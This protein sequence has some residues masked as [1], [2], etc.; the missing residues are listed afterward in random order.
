M[1]K[2]AFSHILLCMLGEI[3]KKMFLILLLNKKTFIYPQKWNFQ[4]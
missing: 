2:N 3:I 1:I 4:T